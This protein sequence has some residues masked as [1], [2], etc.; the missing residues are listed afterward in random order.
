MTEL[1]N[2]NP[3][4]LARKFSSVHF[5]FFLTVPA[6]SISG[7]ILR[8][9]KFFDESKWCC[10]YTLLAKNIQSAYTLLAKNIQSA[11]DTKY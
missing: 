9:A 4:S 3:L 7:L 8:K 6:V 2:E 10:S 5:K 11:S 1:I